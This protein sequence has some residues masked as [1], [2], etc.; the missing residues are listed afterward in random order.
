MTAEQRWALVHRA[1]PFTENELRKHHWT[2]RAARTREWRE[3]FYVL[4]KEEKVPHLERVRIAVT[5]YFTTNVPDAAA[6]MP[7]AKAGIDGLVDAGVLDDDGPE[8]V[9]ATSFGVV[10]MPNVWKK[11]GVTAALG[12]VLEA[13]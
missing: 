13:A 5:H 11:P 12:I 2:W 9:I 1:R 8:H 4:A 10:R 3:A 6:C 7:A